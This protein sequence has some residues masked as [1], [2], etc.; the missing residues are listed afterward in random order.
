MVHN[1]DAFQ[2]KIGFFFHNENLLREAL[3][4]R[5]YLN[6]NPAWR[7]PHNERL[8]FLGDAVLELV[9][10]EFLYEKYPQD[11]EGKLTSIRAALVNYVALA[12]AAVA[13]EMGDYVLMSKGEARDTG[14]AREV[15]LAN[16]FEALLGALYLDGG[17]RVAADFIRAH[18]LSAVDDVVSQ[19]LYR[20]AKSS[21]Q[22]YAQE[23]SKITPTYVVLKEEG[24]DHR[25][26]FTVGVFVGT[27]KIA[28]GQGYS[29]QEAEVEAAKNGLYVLKEAGNKRV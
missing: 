24:P 11:D 12:K 20:D 19:H 18:V 1:T 6:E 28:E 22:E 3:T 8:E 29:K 27:Q 17:Y 13:I 2:K 9:V 23:H 5:S 21:F 4:H 7:L 16:A 26:I 14:K 15:I 25:K 10:T